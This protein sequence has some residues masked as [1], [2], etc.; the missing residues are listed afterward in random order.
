MVVKTLRFMMSIIRR[1]AASCLYGLAPLI[2]DILSRKLERLD[3][4]E[5]D[6]DFD[7]KVCRRHR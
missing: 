7:L 3:M 4:V 6:E 2:Y 5:I 1:Q